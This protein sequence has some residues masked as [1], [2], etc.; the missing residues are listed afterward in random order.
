MKSLPIAKETLALLKEAKQY[1]TKEAIVAKDADFLDQIV[2]QQEYFRKDG[3]NGTVWQDHTSK[4]LQTKSAKKLARQ[5]QKS[6]PF[7][8]LYQL[9]E[10]KTKRKIRH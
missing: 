6:N 2:L 10:D 7:E 1:Q 5:I 4:S 9:V 8:W 3:I